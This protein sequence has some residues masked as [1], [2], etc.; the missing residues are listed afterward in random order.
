MRNAL[1]LAGT[2]L[3]VAVAAARIASAQAV[4]QYPL[5]ISHGASNANV[6]II[7]DNS[8]SM[9]EAMQDPAYNPNT[10]YSGSFS[11]GSSYDISS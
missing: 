5:I 6:L 8:G 4:C 1:G 11:S 9:D 7:Q 3:L 10:T 2:A